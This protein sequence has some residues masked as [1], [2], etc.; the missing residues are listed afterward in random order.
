MPAN[1]KLIWDLIL[2]G[3]GNPYGTA[4]IMGNLMAESSLNPLNMTGRN[5]KQWTDKRAYFDAVNAGTYDPYSFAHDSIAVGLVQWLYW[6]RKQ[7]LLEFAKGRDIGSEEVQI[8][9]MLKE[10]PYYKT[11]WNAVTTA[12][13]IATPCDSFMLRYEKPGTTTEAAMRKRRNYAAGYFDKYYEPATSVPAIQEPAATKPDPNPES[14]VSSSSKN[15]NVVTTVDKVL[16]RCGN[17]KDEYSSIGRIEKMGSSYPLIA[18]SANGWYA[19]KYGKQVGWVSSG[20]SK[21]VEG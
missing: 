10:L 9:Y 17:G 11:V 13:D 12:T 1:E 5:V 2:Q 15:K 19:I 4:A 20:Y 8:G 7:G 14:S 3:V 6:S 21:I 18:V 16:V